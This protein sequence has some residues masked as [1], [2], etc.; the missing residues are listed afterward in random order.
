[1]G[2]KNIEVK[3]VIVPRKMIYKNSLF[4]IT[5]IDQKYIVR[6]YVVRTVDGKIDSVRLDSEHPN[7]DPDTNDFCIPFELKNLPLNERTREYIEHMINIFNID[8]CY[9]TPWGE[10]EYE[11]IEVK[12]W[13]KMR[14][15]GHKESISSR[16]SI[17]S[18]FIE[19]KVRKI[20]ER[21]R[22]MIQNRKRGK[23]D[24]NFK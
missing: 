4:R 6:S 16:R 9:F 17:L 12:D 2:I 20:F 13:L 24:D 7:S 14:E 19:D 11:K 10:I 21:N 23:I 15:K 18:K 5:D 22:I 8:N 1:M 3:K